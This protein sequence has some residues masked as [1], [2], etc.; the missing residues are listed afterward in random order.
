MGPYSYRDLLPVSHPWF[1]KPYLKS[2]I[3]ILGIKM[4]EPLKTADKF[5]ESQ[6]VKCLTLDYESK[7][8]IY[9]H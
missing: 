9:L 1:G 6:A 2:Y 8:D 4:G 3:N 5:R 7:I